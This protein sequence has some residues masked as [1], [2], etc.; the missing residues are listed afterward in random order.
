MHYTYRRFQKMKLIRHG[1]FWMGTND[2]RSE[3]GEY[4]LREVPVRS[5]YLDIHPVIN[6]FYW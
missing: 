5:F 4:P 6:A 3:T 1:K 2:P